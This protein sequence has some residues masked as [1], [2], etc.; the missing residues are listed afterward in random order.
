[1]N[2]KRQPAAPAPLRL[3]RAHIQPAARMLART[4]ADEPLWKYFIPNAA[5]RHQKIH[6]IFAL[7]LTYGARHGESY[8]TSPN[9]EGVAVWLPSEHTQMSLW[10]ML[11][12]GAIPAFLSLGPQTTAHISAANA[13][14][15]ATRAR[16]APFPHHYL[17]LVGVDPAHQGQGFAGALL[18]PMFA[19][20]DAEGR[21]CY[22]ETH[23]EHNL[24]IYQHY[25]FEA[26][27]EGAFP[28]SDTR[29][30]AMVRAPQTQ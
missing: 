16:N 3:T 13:Y 2:P 14:I 17:S 1:M 27:E 21:P 4:F 23:T 6:H 10:D 11:R 7:M 30:V 25:G 19:R 9:L 8:I 28:H 26:R 29:Y 24:Q 18:R 20:L 22:L 12:C 15:D 5:Q